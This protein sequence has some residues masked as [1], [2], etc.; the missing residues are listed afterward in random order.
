MSCE[1]SSIAWDV[2]ILKTINLCFLKLKFSW[3]VC[4]LFYKSGN[5]NTPRHTHAHTHTVKESFNPLCLLL[6]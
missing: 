1:M 5:S 4:N 2:F 3:V 6:K